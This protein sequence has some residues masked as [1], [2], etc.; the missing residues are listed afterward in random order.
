MS[1]CDRGTWSYSRTDL[2][3]TQ[4]TIHVL[5]GGLLRS[6]ACWSM[7]TSPNGLASFDMASNCS[8][9]SAKG[10]D[11][12]NALGWFIPQGDVLGL[13]PGNPVSIGCFSWQQHPIPKS[14]VNVG[15]SVRH[16]QRQLSKSV[17]IQMGPRVDSTQRGFPLH[18]SRL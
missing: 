18:N 7:A 8:R 3:G 6:F 17:S 12:A 2:H 15:K 10:S 9:S 16:G 14:P 11:L 4:R 5:E 13:T 1:S